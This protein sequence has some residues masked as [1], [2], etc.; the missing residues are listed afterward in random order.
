MSRYCIDANVIITAWQRSYPIS[1]FPSLW[2]QLLEYKDDLI[3]LSPIYDEIE[4]M[5]PNDKKLGSEEKERKYPIRMWLIKNEFIGVSVDDEINEH[6]LFLE[7]S[8]QIDESSQGVSQND[9]TLI[10]YAKVNRMT[11]VTLESM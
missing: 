2:Q 11:V 8:Y 9:L 7:Q 3:I 4:P 10:A 1:I 6:S 5:S